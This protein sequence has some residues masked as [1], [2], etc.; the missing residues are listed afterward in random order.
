MLKDHTLLERI[1]TAFSYFMSNYCD[2]NSFNYSPI[3]DTDPL[4]QIKYAFQL[5]NI[6]FES[7][8]D[9]SNH[10]MQRNITIKLI[11]ELNNSK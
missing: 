4:T 7:T 11:D 8:L 1:E 9:N 3:R 5:S 10:H 2:K 6:H